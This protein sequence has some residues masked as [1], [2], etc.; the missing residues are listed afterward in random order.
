MHIELQKAPFGRNFH[1]ILDDWLPPRMPD[2]NRRPKYNT[3]AKSLQ[4]EKEKKKKKSD[5]LL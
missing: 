1:K 5:M 2:L 4:G 3:L